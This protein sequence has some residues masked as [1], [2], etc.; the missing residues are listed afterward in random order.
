M[1]T[2]V[3]YIYRREKLTNTLFVIAPTGKG[4]YVEDGKQYTRE[5]FTKKY[6]LPV[7]FVCHNKKNADTTKSFMETD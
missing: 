4:F 3:E 6:P 1:I 5:E 2:L 7:S